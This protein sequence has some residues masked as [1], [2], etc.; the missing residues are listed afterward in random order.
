MVEAL[1]EDELWDIAFAV[2]HFLDRPDL[3]GRLLGSAYQP[4]L[5][6]GRLST[7]R[8]WSEF[9]RRGGGDS[10]IALLVN[11]EVALREGSLEKART[12]AEHVA[13][14][15]EGEAAAQAH[16]VAA[17]AAHLLE[18]ASGLEHLDL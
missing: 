1:T 17:R 13:R 7:L 14:S 4:L 9:A 18:E 15:L 11:A 10:A 2:I 8:R 12:L 6:Q 16:L 5:D 3:M